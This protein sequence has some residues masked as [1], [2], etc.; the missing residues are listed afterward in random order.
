MFSYLTIGIIIGIL[1]M[2]SVTIT[3]KEVTNNNIF[4]AI[5]TIAI[6]PLILLY[7]IFK[8]IGFITQKIVK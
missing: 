8:F 6:W 3:D 7:Y 1:L 5:L 4:W 2:I